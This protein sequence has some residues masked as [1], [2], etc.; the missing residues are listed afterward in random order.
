MKQ[1]TFSQNEK[2]QRL[3]CSWRFFII[4]FCDTA[5][6]TC[7][8]EIRPPPL[9]TFFS[10]V[11]FVFNLLLLPLQSSSLS[12]CCAVDS[13]CPPLPPVPLVSRTLLPGRRVVVQSR[14][15]TRVTAVGVLKR[16][17]GGAGGP[18]V[19]RP[20]WLLLLNFCSTSSSSS[21]AVGNRR[22]RR[23]LVHAA[24]A[25]VLPLPYQAAKA[26]IDWLTNERP[27]QQQGEK[28][29]ERFSL[30][31]MRT[32]VCLPATTGTTRGWPSLA[33]PGLG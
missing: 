23:R 15:A 8:C 30:V 5:A 14:L 33:W 27:Q 4:V 16:L 2:Q 25:A 28:K 3:Q 13:L 31:V 11:V 12:Y 29:R 22:R 18:P 20:R 26:R 6:V 7:V 9:S 21:S 19:C 1:K 10:N 17:L 24:A 32:Y